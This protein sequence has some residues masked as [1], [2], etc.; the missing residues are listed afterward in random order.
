M[1]KEISDSFNGSLKDY[2]PFPKYQDHASY[3]ALPAENRSLAIKNAEKYLHFNFTGIPATVFMEYVRTGNRKDFETLNF[4]KRYALNALIL[5][6]CYEHSGRFTDDIINGVYS[7]C[8]ESAWQLPAHNSYVRDTPSHILPDVTDP[9]ID[10]FAAETGALLATIS[11][12]FYDE[13]DK[14][15]PV[16]NKMIKAKLNERIYKP[17]MERH[18]WWMGNGDEPMCNWT[19]WCT[20]NVLL[21]VFLNPDTDADFRNAVLKKAAYSIDSFLKDYGEDGCCDEGALYYSHSALCL[22]YC[23]RILNFVTENAF[24][25][26]YS[27]PKIKNIATYIFKVNVSGSYYFN[28]ADCSAVLSPAGAGEFLFAREIGDEEM[29]RFAAA[30]YKRDHTSKTEEE[31]NL[32]QVLSSEFTAPDMLNFDTDRP[33]VHSDFYYSSVGVFIAHDKKLSVSVKAG[34]NNDSHNHNDTGSLIVYK[35]GKPVLIDVGVETYTKDTFSDKRYDIWTMQSAYHNLPTVNNVM[36]RNGEKYRATNVETFLSDN[37]SD[38]R[39]DIASAYPKEANLKS[40]TRH[41]SL[42]KN[43]QLVIEDEISFVKGDLDNN[44]YFLS[45]MT[46]EKPCIHGNSVSIGNANLQIIGRCLISYETIAINDARLKWAWK[47]DIYRI[48]IMP[49]DSKLMMILN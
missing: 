40:Y 25:S 42:Y 34:D 17:Y 26:V 13:F 14:I 36:Q 38:I 3:D 28:Y 30:D 27:I 47:H 12:L 2:I 21:S 43:K 37:I 20:Q 4:T 24:N 5:G 7:I 18:F 39:M 44:S 10:L 32:Y 35:E 23:T 41:V 15:S 46:Y 48:I 1:Y 22:Y 31:L 49:A 33:I 45:F 16:I 6:E 29:M 8:E 9:I 19:V 11:Y